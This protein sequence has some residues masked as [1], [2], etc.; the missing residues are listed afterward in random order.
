MKCLDVIIVLKFI[1][2]IRVVRRV[3]SIIC[4]VFILF[5]CVWWNFENLMWK[6]VIEFLIKIDVK[7]MGKYW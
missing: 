6:K 4:I 1:I 2:G 5:L 7:E 3:F